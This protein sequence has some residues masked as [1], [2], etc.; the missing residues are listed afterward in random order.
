MTE[1]STVPERTAIHSERE[2]V[3]AEARVRTDDRD[4]GVAS[5]AHTAPASLHA[6]MDAQQM[7]GHRPVPQES[8]IAVYGCG[9][10]RHGH[11]AS[12]TLVQRLHPRPGHSP[13]RPRLQRHDHAAF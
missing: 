1:S 5:R 2:Q 7:P 13:S 8:W 9:V 10:S 6:G 3:V 12:G 11:T 4:H